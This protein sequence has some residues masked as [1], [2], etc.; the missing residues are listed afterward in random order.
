MKTYYITWWNLENLFE[1]EDSSSR[2][3]WLRDYLER[4][5]KGWTQEVL[6]RKL[7]QLAL[8]IRLLN[9]GKGPDILSV[10]EV[11][12]ETVLRQLLAKLDD[13]GR[14]YEI[15]LNEGEDKRG[16]DV[17]FVY[18]ADQFTAKEKFSHRV[19]KR[20]PTR[21]VFQVNFSTASGQDLILIGN[22]WPARMPDTHASEPYR[23]IAAETLSYWISRILEVKGKDVALMALGD[24]NDSPF[25]RSF[26][27]YALSTNDIQKVLGARSSPWLYNLMAAP[28]GGGLGSV[29]YSGPFMFDQ[30]LVNRGMV[31]PTSRLKVLPETAEVNNFDIMTTG[32]Y[33]KPRRFGRPSSKST[34]DPDGFSDHFPVSVKIREK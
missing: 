16:I 31:K 5:L 7:D 28:Y 20:T 3:E 1:A 21:D 10:C 4:E 6:D 2:P 30:I 32:R 29:Y 14:N 19:T 26:M 25:D 9:D 8:V 23:I 17:A 24:F 13:L 18:D 12:S 22:H 15:A 33:R 11:E 34:Y 27:E